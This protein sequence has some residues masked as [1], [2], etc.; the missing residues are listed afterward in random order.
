MW[1][2]AKVT[3]CS[4]GPDQKRRIT[5]ADTIITGCAQGLSVV[6]GISRSGITESSL[7]LRG[8]EPYDA[9][10]LSFFMSIPMIVL[11]IA[12]FF[13]IEGFG[14]LTALAAGTGIVAAFLASIA[15]MRFMLYAAERVPFYAFN[16]AIG[17]LALVPFGLQV[18]AG[19]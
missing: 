15:T 9:V 18:F 19:G 10:R 2:S 8:Y 3:V 16:I 17:L 6:P 11:S 13:F 5:L 1:R 7:L 12:T 4:H 14:S